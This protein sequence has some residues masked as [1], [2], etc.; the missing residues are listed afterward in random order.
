[1][2]C[3]TRPKMAYSQF[4]TI[5]IIA[6]FFPIHVWMIKNKNPTILFSRN[7]VESGYSGNIREYAAQTSRSLWLF[8]PIWRGKVDD[9]DESPSGDNWWGWTY[10]SISTRGTVKP[11]QQYIALTFTFIILKL[12]K[13]TL[14]N[15]LENSSGES[16]ICIFYLLYNM[17]FFGSSSYSF[18]IF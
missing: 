9:H 16:F 11:I 4:M 1:M 14:E 18:H 6:S 8:S 17:F 5:I 2:Y 12:L 13:S 3:A 15:S 7:I 10:R